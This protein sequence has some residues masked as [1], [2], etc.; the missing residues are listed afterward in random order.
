M[1]YRDLNSPP[2]QSMLEIV[3]SLKAKQD[4]Q[5]TG[6]HGVKDLGENGDVT[7]NVIDPVTGEPLEKSMRERVEALDGLDADLTDLN[8][9]IL[10]S[11]QDGT[12]I[13]DEAI[14]ARTIAAHSIGADKIIA[15]EIG[16]AVG[17]FVEINA[18]QISGGSIAGETITGGTFVGGEI[19]TTADPQSTGGVVIGGDGGLEAYGPG[20]V[21]TVDIDQATGKVTLLGDIGQEN[22]FASMALGPELSDATHES[23]ALSFHH[24]GATWPLSA[25]VALI[26][27]G[28]GKPNLMMQGLGGPTSGLSQLHLAAGGS[29][30]HTRLIR[31]SADGSNSGLQI[32]QNNSV[33][34]K[35]D[36][37]EV[38]IESLNSSANTSNSHIRVKPTGV[39]VHGRID[40]DGVLAVGGAMSVQGT[41]YHYGTVFLP[42]APN[43][44]NTP[45]AYIGAD[46]KVWKSTNPSSRRYK[47]DITPWAPTPEQVL[48]LQPV[49][50]EYIEPV[51]AYPG[52]PTEGNRLVGFIAEDVDELGLPGLVE[53]SEDEDGN[54][55]PD[56]VR[57]DRF[58]AAQQV[59]L[60]KHERDITALRDENKQLRAQL[61]VL[62]ARLDAAGI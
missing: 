2:S 53:Y 32:R 41:E 15:N 57:Y 35:S 31:G 12:Y 28:N 3:R 45:N 27:T 61:D 10:P 5:K 60:Q 9:N 25:A 44:S 52:G 22:D 24:K 13:G 23:P 21:K 1:K 62:T 18:E 6:A 37:N 51:A 19:R 47:K 29:D 43:V 34:L 55:R 16:A 46:G 54:V 14:T 26:D 36:D 56:S 4:E 39:S 11:I 42:N 17:N 33:Y 59:V 58:P 49:E 8:E 40:A 7:W 20:G 38:V 50:W 48:A 30:Q